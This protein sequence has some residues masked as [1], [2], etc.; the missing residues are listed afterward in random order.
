MLKLQVFITWEDPLSSSTLA[1]TTGCKFSGRI[2]FSCPAAELPKIESAV[3][4]AWGEKA[5]LTSLVSLDT[6]GKATVQ[7][8]QS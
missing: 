5:I 2:A 7:V 1:D 6:P 8:G 4:A 3:K